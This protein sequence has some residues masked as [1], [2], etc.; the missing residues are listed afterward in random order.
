M[1]SR[2]EKVT[3]MELLSSCEHQ[4]PNDEGKS[5]AVLCVCKA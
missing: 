2:M 1:V 4:R 5:V 3:R